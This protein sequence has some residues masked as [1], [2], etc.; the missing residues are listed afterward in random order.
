MSQ[1][2][3]TIF[4]SSVLTSVPSQSISVPSIFQFGSGFIVSN[5]YITGTPTGGQ[6]SLDYSNVITNTPVTVPILLP[7]E[8]QYPSKPYL[9]ISPASETAAPLFTEGGIIGVNSTSVDGIITCSLTL[10]KDLHLSSPG[11]QKDALIN[12]GVFF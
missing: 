2:G 9:V 5:I 4:L 7:A 8:Y 6:I 10:T 11:L 1:R 3:D 12:Y